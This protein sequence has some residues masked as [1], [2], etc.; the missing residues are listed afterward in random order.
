MNLLSSLPNLTLAFILLIIASCAYTHTLAFN[1]RTAAL[2]PSMFTTLGIFA[3]FLGIALGLLHFDA[4]NIQASVPDLLDGLR[5]A[6]WAS[7]F[8]VGGALTVKMRVA[9]LGLPTKKGEAAHPQ[10]AT[11]DDL[12]TH[13]VAV[14]KALVGSDD[15]TL[16]T[17]LK[18]GRQE[19]NDRLE[20]IRKVVEEF[21][22]ARALGCVM[23]DS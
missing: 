17:Q 16:I 18:L 5:T 15:S 9:I 23:R 1:A 10:G 14:Q 22:F 20:R 2:A 3:T 11:I 13:L 8:G 19:S 4:R 21:T 12:A 6:F 7:V